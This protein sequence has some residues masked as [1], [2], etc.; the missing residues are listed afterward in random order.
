MAGQK[1]RSGG[2]RPGAGRP[3][4]RVFYVYGL[5]RDVDCTDVFYIGKGKGRRMEVHVNDSDPVT[6]E[7]KERLGFL[8]M[9]KLRIDISEDEAFAL[10]RKLIGQSIIRGAELINRNAGTYP[11]PKG[12]NPS[13]KHDEFMKNAVRSLETLLQA[14]KRETQQ[15]VDTTPMILRRLTEIERLLGMRDKVR[16]E[17]LSR[18]NP[19]SRSDAA[20]ALFKP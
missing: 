5:Y 18:R 19:M 12:Y 8:P 17:R 10:E 3:K 1:G 6:V 16:A 4:S 2:A 20:E 13:Q 15:M 7:V 9:K 14:S 11:Y